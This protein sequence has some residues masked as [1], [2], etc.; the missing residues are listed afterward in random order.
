MT[1]SVINV[2]MGKQLFFTLVF[3]EIGRGHSTIATMRISHYTK[4]E[5]RTEEVESSKMNST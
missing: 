1:E 5:K 3:N 2:L 4:V